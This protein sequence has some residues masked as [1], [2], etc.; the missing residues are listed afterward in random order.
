MPVILWSEWNLPRNLLKSDKK[1]EKKTHPQKKVG[2]IATKERSRSNSSWLLTVV[3]S[4]LILMNWIGLGSLV[5][6][7]VS[8]L[9]HAL[10]ESFQKD[11]KQR[12]TLK[13]FFSGGKNQLA[14]LCSIFGRLYVM[15]C[16]LVFVTATPPDSF[17]Y[18]LCSCCSA[19][20]P[21]S[22]YR[23]SLILRDENS[24]NS[25]TLPSLLLRCLSL[26]FLMDSWWNLC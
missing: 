16:W 4:H 21:M 9:H 20:P 17:P 22:V 26:L 15:R 2:K 7:V 10:Q 14:L 13:K 23:F 19:V 12:K 24:S 25:V 11:T 5:S 18:H 6:W 8:H 1:E 3:P